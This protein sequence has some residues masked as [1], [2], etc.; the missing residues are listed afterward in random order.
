[1]EGKKETSKMHQS[2]GKNKW[3]RLGTT[4]ATEIIREY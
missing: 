4:Q 3:P 2:V 1:M